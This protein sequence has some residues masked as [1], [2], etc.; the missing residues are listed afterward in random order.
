M[1]DTIGSE[2][3]KVQSWL[4]RLETL[5]DDPRV[6][7]EQLAA[8]L[9]SLFPTAARAA[10]LLDWEGPALSI[11]DRDK[12]Q[13][14][15]PAHHLLAGWTGR[16][17]EE[18]KRLGAAFSLRT[19]GVG[20][21]QAEMVEQVGCRERWY[22]VLAVLFPQGAAHGPQP[23]GLGGVLRVAA[24]TAGLALEARRQARAGARV[25]SELKEQ[26]RLADVGEMAGQ[27]THRFN[28]FLNSLLLKLAVIEPE[29]SPAVLTK[30][31]DV[32]QQA[33]AT[34]DVI[35]QL[36]K[37]RH[38]GN[39]AQ[40]PFDLNLLAREAAHEVE[41]ESA[42]LIPPR[43]GPVQLTL[44]PEPVWVAGSAIDLKRLCTFLLRSGTHQPNPAGDPVILRTELAVGKVLLTVED[45][46]AQVAA[47]TLPYLF[48]LDSKGPSEGTNKLTLAAS[49]AI[50][51]RLQGRIQ[52]DQRVGGG[53]VVT[54]ELPPAAPP[55]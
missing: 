34:A 52:A 2:V 46:R 27:V 32:K 41:T 31:A 55:N 15:K 47:A 29:L 49:K 3:D 23:V 20:A 18:R 14:A 28:N 13:Q 37:V 8:A 53:L 30:M 12:T 44:H 50:V 22:G 24:R 17:G 9:L 16:N 6:Q 19:D 5:A 42:V 11:V 38:Q 25:Q 4:E 45:P 35:K 33:R 54:V 21:K 1:A 43:T 40:G 48:E 10:C 39:S 51:R 7:A 36:H 26:I